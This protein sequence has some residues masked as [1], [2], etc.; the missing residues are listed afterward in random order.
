[1]AWPGIAVVRSQQRSGSI[2]GTIYSATL[3]ASFCQPEEDA[4]R[5]LDDFVAEHT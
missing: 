3:L 5:R 2:V 4:V 1:M